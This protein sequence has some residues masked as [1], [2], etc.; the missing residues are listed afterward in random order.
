MSSIAVQLSAA[1]L[2]LHA[3]VIMKSPKIGRNFVIHCVADNRQVRFGAWYISTLCPLERHYN[4]YSC[5]IAGLEAESIGA[6]KMRLAT[7]Q[8]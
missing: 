1:C 8:I 6:D 2:Q 3:K 5:L 4:K 7:K